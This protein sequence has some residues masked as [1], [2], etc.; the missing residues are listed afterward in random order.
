MRKLPHLLFVV[1]L[2]SPRYPGGSSCG[3]HAVWSSLWVSILSTIRIIRFAMVFNT[4]TSLVWKM[5]LYLISSFVQGVSLHSSIMCFWVSGEFLQY[6]HVVSFG[7]CFFGSFSQVALM[8]WFLTLGLFGRRVI[9]VTCVCPSVRLS[10]WLFPSSL[11]T[12]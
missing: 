2:H 5:F 3:A 6:L 4:C 7:I 10:V 1:V 12:Q 9:V 8:F 11:L